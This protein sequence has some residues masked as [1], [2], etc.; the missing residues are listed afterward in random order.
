MILRK[1]LV[2]SI[3]LSSAIFLLSP[4]LIAEKEKIDVEVILQAF[5]EDF[6]KNDDLP[7]EPLEFGI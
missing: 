6:A 5:V 7:E 4:A 3:I 1:A 2:F